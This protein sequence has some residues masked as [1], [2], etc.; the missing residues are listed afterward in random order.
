MISSVGVQ[1]GAKANYWACQY[2]WPSARN[3]TEQ[4]NHHHDQ[5][6]QHN[7][8]YHH[9]HQYQQSTNFLGY[10]QTINHINQNDRSAARATHPGPAATSSETLAQTIHNN[11]TRYYQGQHQQQ[12][13]HQ[14]SGTNGT[15]D[16]ANL[17]PNY[18]HNYHHHHPHHSHHLHHHAQHNHLNHQNQHNYNSVPVYP[19]ASDRPSE[20]AMQSQLAQ[21]GEYHSEYPQR[22]PYIDQAQTGSSI[23]FTQIVSLNQSNQIQ[24]Q[25]QLQTQ[26]QAQAQAYTNTLPL[27]GSYSTG[28]HYNQS[29]Y[30]GASEPPTSDYSHLRCVE[31]PGGDTYGAAGY[32]QLTGRYQAGAEVAGPQEAEPVLAITNGNCQHY[33]SIQ[34]S[35]ITID[36]NY[37]RRLDVGSNLV[38][39]DQSLHCN[40][41][42]QQPQQQQHQQNPYYDYYKSQHSSG[43]NLNNYTVSSNYQQQHQ[44]A[45][46]DHQLTQTLYSPPTLDNNNAIHPQE[47]QQQVVRVSSREL[48][49]RG[50][51]HSDSIAPNQ[52]QT[53]SLRDATAGASANFDLDYAACLDTS[54]ANYLLLVG[55]SDQDA[56]SKTAAPIKMRT[57][58]NNGQQRPDAVQIGS[59]RSGVVSNNNAGADVHSQQHQQH[60]L[61]QSKTNQCNI[62]GRHYARPST[63]KTHLRTH[64]N[65]RP[66][67]CS[68][69]CKTFSQAANLTAHQ[70]VH[71]GERPFPCPICGRQFSQSSSVITHLRT[72]SGK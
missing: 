25:T 54:K 8:H 40:Q 43:T 71:T 10:L 64:T 52:G 27:I 5:Q 12:Q 61:Q 38:G 24:L 22:G 1:R 4:H 65:E 39:N 41:Q 7:H 48:A 14:H 42:Q 67:K 3:D 59:Q 28:N 53:W 11:D 13:Q 9:H 36:S 6:Q 21:V 62:C 23:Q 16:N 49:K 33:D 70:R 29:S 68:V 60:Q 45:S 15:P 44:I 55:S 31:P 63:L 46:S 69:C 58:D 72:H 51:S 30:A 56:H 47:Q 19:R 32:Q 66:Y 34:L 35:S 26:T 57:K 37:N 20:A 17:Y 50:S 2:G 18:Y